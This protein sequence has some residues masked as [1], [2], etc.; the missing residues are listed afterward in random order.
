MVLEY[1]NEKRTLKSHVV[2]TEIYIFRL[3][4]NGDTSL[5][6]E[7]NTHSFNIFSFTTAR[8]QA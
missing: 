7:K 1:I 4:K 2:K 5:Q 3:Q 8:K 6:G